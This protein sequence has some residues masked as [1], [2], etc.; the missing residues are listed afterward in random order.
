MDG[1]PQRT[2][3]GGN[4]RLHGYYAF[5]RDERGEPN[6]QGNTIPGFGDTRALAPPDRDPERDARLR[7]QPGQRGPL[8][9]Q[10]HQHHVRAERGREPRR[11]S[12]SATASRPRWCCRRS[13]CRAS[14]STS[15]APRASRRAAPT[16]RSS[17]RTRLSYLR[18]RH[19]FKVGGEYRRFHNVNFQTNGG[20][21]TFA[22][23]ADFQAG[24]GQRVHRHAGRH[25]QRRRP[26]RPSASSCRTTCALRSNLTLELGFRYDLNVAPTEAD[27]RFVYFDPAT[28]L[29]AAG[30]RRAGRDKIY[31]NK[32]NC[33]PRVG[34][35]WDPFER[36]P[37]RGARR[38]RA[39]DRPAGH[40][41]GDADRRQPAARH[42][43]HASPGRRSGSTTRST[44]AGPAGLA[45]QQRGRGL[46][47]P[48]HP[49][50]ERQRPARARAAT[51]ARWSATSASKGD[52]LRVSRNLNQFG[53][54]R[55]GPFPRLSADSPILSRRGAR[56][57]HRGHQPRLLAL[58]RRCGSR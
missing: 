37:H 58:R 18:G 1:R 25:R 5:Q 21:F 55:R 15:A 51:S 47:Q 27:D 49:D 8:R 53:E 33:Q 4:D 16:P 38:L 3:S 11:A 40:Q 57:H 9:L 54:R 17:S 24:R 13:P 29:A 10:P 20:T 32:G 56:Q 48:A 41:P 28:R 42:A 52:R 22:S 14:A 7:A 36:R 31:D 35:V 46:P 44:V 6:L 30:G 34:V 50:L 45:P 19:S 39:A 12:A 23:L 2:S 26:S 43:A